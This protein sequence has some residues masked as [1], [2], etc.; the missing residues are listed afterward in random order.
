MAQACREFG[1]SR[2]TGYKWLERYED[3]GLDGLHDRSRAPDN[4]PHKT[5]ENT[6]ES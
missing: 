5:D 3:E 2:P 4:I 1:I 6:E